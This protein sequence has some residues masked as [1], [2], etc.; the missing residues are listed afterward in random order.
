MCFFCGCKFSESRK[1]GLEVNT[2]KHAYFL[3]NVVGII[4]NRSDEWLDQVKKQI[5]G[6]ELMDARYHKNCNIIFQN[7]KNVPL[8][9]GVSSSKK[10]GRPRN[11]EF[12]EA[13]CNLIHLIQ[14][15]TGRIFSI[16]DLAELASLM[17][18]CV[19]SNTI[20]E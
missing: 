4:G 9:H 3:E 6:K 5:E 15:E 20:E 1:K 16:A 14:N 10:L 18:N 12:D 7:Y 13:F 2:V 8:C 11:D 19:K 17:N